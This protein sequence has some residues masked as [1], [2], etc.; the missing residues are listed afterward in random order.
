VFKVI[1]TAGDT[2]LGGEDFDAGSS[3][4]SSQASRSSTA[5]IC[6]RTAW[7]CS[8]SRTPPRRPSASSRASRDRDQ[9]AVHHLDGRNE[10]L[11][12]QRTLT[13]DELEELTS[14]LVERTVDIC[15]RTS[16]TPSSKDEIEDVVLVGGMTRMPRSSARSPSSSARAVQGR[17]PRRG[18][19][20]GAAIQGAALMDEGEEDI[21]LLDVTPHTLGIMTVGKLLRGAHPAEHHGA[22][23]ERTKIFTTSRDNQ[24]R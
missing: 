12:L 24:T 7:R 13:R 8:A 9:P 20:L 22:H 23:L 4:G 14:D 2:F 19:R 6:A 17:A 21:L 10:A 15:A 1:A 16:R 18:R 3:T 5:S 11:H